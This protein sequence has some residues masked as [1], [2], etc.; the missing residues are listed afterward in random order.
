M[1]ISIPDE[2]IYIIETLEKR[3]YEAYVVGGCVRN[4]ILG[5]EPKDW[6]ICTTALPDETKRCFEGC[7]IV[8]TGLQHGT[9]TLVLNQKP[10]E[11]TTYR[12]DGLYSDN[13]HPDEVVFVSDLKADLS[14]RDFTINSMAYNPKDGFVDCFGGMSDIESRMIRCV[15]EA[16]KRFQ[17]DALRILRALRFS[18]ELDFDIEGETSA[19]IL[20]NKNLLKNIAA[21]RISGEINRLIVGRNAENVLL[22]YA[23]VVEVIVPEI[24]EMVGFPQNNPYHHMDVWRHTAASV[25][26]AP[27]DTSLRLAMLFHDIAKPRSYSEVNSVG[28]FYGHARL[29]SDMAKEILTRLK[30]DND[31]IKT[32]AQLVLYHDTKILPER[33]DIKR[34]LN[35]IGEKR[36]RRLIE[37]KR[38]DASAQSEKFRSGKLAE[39]DRLLD[40]LNEILELR[41]CFSLR[42]LAIDGNDLIAI[43]MPEGIQVGK[44]L[45]SLLEMVIN[46]SVKNEK[47]ELLRVC[48]LT[49]GPFG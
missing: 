26:Q 1:K 31:T 41:Q 5:K 8:E 3:G 40:V 24:K 15:G 7:H 23:S 37:V 18:S 39:L 14:R 28:H 49:F 25:S 45:D 20:R 11:I 34:W 38:A 4:A 2:V 16:N 43:G 44:V 42:D 30:Y 10:F 29:S 9:I 46:E 32:I 27:A 12:V 17:E 35:R 13:R 19:A 47:D 6:D 36:F 48:L 22:S 21:E 33:K